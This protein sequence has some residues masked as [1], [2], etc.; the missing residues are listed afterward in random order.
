MNFDQT[1]QRH[2]RGIELSKN[3]K[4]LVTFD[5]HSRSRD[6]RWP[7]NTFF[8][9]KF[10]PKTTHNSANFWSNSIIFVLFCCWRPVL[11]FGW[12][13][14]TNNGSMCLLAPEKRPSYTT[15]HYYGKLHCRH[16]QLRIMG[17]LI[18]TVTVPPLISLQ[19]HTNAFRKVLLR[20]AHSVIVK[21]AYFLRASLIRPTPKPMVF[22]GVVH[23]PYDWK[24]LIM[25]MTCTPFFTNLKC[26]L[27][28]SIWW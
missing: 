28:W 2:G 22:Y 4:I 27:W 14:N 11:H 1:L 10:G 26:D 16:F 12:K 20:A 5:L 23:T 13:S 9:V 3:I 24:G 19:W 17:K 6:P 21:W 25:R 15:L 18:Q 7:P 8:K